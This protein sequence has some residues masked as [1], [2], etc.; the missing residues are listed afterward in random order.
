MNLSRRQMLT[1]TGAGLAVAALS[2]GLLADPARAAIRGTIA[3]QQTGP[4]PGA[5]EY[6]FG[7]D[8]KFALVTAEGVTDPTGGYAD[9]YQPGFDD[10][11]WRV[12]DV[13]HDWSIELA[14]VNASYTE[15]FNGFLPGGLAWYRKKFTLPQW[16]SGKRISVEFDGV[17]MN[18]NVYV[19]GTFLGNHP[20][21]YTG[22]NYDLT[23]LVH[24]DGTT[25]NVIAVQASN[26]IP[27][28]RWY[29]GSGI[30][31]NV[32]V[33]VT[34][35][36]HIARHGTFI[37]T[38]DAATTIP[39]GYAH[40]QVAT[41]IQNDG[42]DSASVT[43]ALRARD[44]GGAVV[45]SGS[46]TLSVDA[47]GTQTATTVLRVAD[48]AL[49]S[50]G[51][52]AL[53]T[54]ETAVITAGRTVDSSTRPFGIRFFEFDPDEGFSLNGQHMK[55][56]GVDL[57]ATQG[58]LGAAIHEDSIVRQ[59]RLM[60][61]YGVNAIRT[62]HNPPA[63]ELVAAAQQLGVLLMVEA[64]DCWHT[65][66]L[67]Y[68]YHLYFDEWGD[69]DIKEM[70]LAHRNSPAIVLWSIGN[71]TPDTGLPDGPPIATRLMADVQSIDTSR[72]V[73][74]GS[75]QYRS[76]PQTGSPQDLI[77]NTLDGLG[78]NYNTAMSMDGLHAKYGSKF[79]FCSETSSET[80]TRGYYQ[81]PQLLN[82]GANFTP[83]RCETSSY[84]NNL[85]SWCMS[86][87]YELKKDRDRLFWTGGFLWAGQDY[88]GEPTPYDQFPV[89]ASF[90]GAIDTAGFGKDAR[91]LYASQWTTAPMVH[92]VPMD[93]TS[94][95]AGSPV[96]V[97]VYANVPSV[98]LFL[99]G[100]SLGKKSFDTKVTTFGETYLETSEPTGDD[101]NYPSGS[102]TSPNGSTGKLH[103]AWSVPFEPGVL[104]AVGYGTAGGSEVA[105]DE[106][107]TAGPA[108]A[109]TLTPSQSATVL[110]ADG[111]SLA[112]VTASVVDARGVVVPGATNDIRFS[113][114]GAGVLKATDNGRQ[115]NPRGYTSGTQA[116]FF[117]QAL[118]V[119]GAGREPG[120]I[121]LTAVAEGL[122]PAQLRL[123]AVSTAKTATLGSATGLP[124]GA[125]SAAVSASAAS[126]ASADDSGP[127]ADASFS[128]QPD[129]LPAMMLDG[130]ASTYWSNYYVA[131]QT[132]NL[133]AVSVSD[134][135]DW[136]SLSWTSAQRLSGLTA[137]FVTGGAL[138][139]PVS[140][141][142]SYWNSRELVTVSDVQVSWATA[143]NQP[144]TITFAPVTTTEIRLTMTSA[145]PGTGG[146]FL[147]ISSLAANPA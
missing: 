105:R 81:D 8:W 112:Y 29:S 26:Q 140:V 40:V 73:V 43:L 63:P 119:V 98:E 91:F 16:M 136:V 46:A 18:S 31:R 124:G 80:S 107:Q 125:A 95:G 19:N 114:S 47:G 53:Y 78:V 3:G 139:L 137:D 127:T 71:E 104:I 146:G 50:V 9:A 17:Y 100:R 15:S 49:W 2:G 77:V 141:T 10:S 12:L 30:Y 120:A 62:A 37:T 69:R 59:L 133:L 113:V 11:T 28:S 145:S 51:N 70:V 38:P 89:K 4:E 97:W 138:A 21:A 54:L 48:P 86:G 131:A 72:P 84:D 118:A 87:E 68:D 14:P 52:P 147:A 126:A 24:T 121:T 117:G 44:A 79:F 90:F 60:K 42:P 96:S 36:V 93:W 33:V 108:R 41:D 123:T 111:Q 13:P 101:Y 128:G 88:I 135:S 32:R 110:A 106:V 103:L 115:E 61:S 25:P 1:S 39:A 142:V 134:P 27:S 56:H 102:Y 23:S 144:T 22:F 34:D 83:G 130:D 143:S 75:D 85:S 7:Q 67:P 92:V 74:M 58:P 94:W 65:G 116:A 6:D 55:L 129:T 109:L 99:N 5:R 66:K 20:Y 132:A 76:V 57:H 45:A 35:P 64:F 122:A 82:T